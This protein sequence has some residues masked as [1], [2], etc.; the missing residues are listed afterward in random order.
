MRHRLLGNFIGILLGIALNSALCST[1]FAQKNDTL[2]WDL[3]KTK[4]QTLT[5]R[6]IDSPRIHIISFHP[7]GNQMCHALVLLQRGEYLP[8][9]DI[10]INDSLGRPVQR[11]DYAQGV[12][13]NYFA[14]GKINNVLTAPRGKTEQRYLEYYSNG[15]IKT[16]EVA[17]KDT[18][19]NGIKFFPPHL[20]SGNRL[21]PY[22]Y[23]NEKYGYYHRYEYRPNG[24]RYKTVSIQKNGTYV[25]KL[26]NNK[27]AETVLEGDHQ[28][29]IKQ[30]WYENGNMRSEE[31]FLNGIAHGPYRRWYEDGTPEL[32]QFKKQNQN[33]SIMRMWYPDGSLKHFADYRH[34]S[35]SDGPQMRFFPNGRLEHI[36]AGSLTCRYDSLGNI[37]VEYVSGAGAFNISNESDRARFLHQGEMNPTRQGLWKIYSVDGVLR[38]Q[39]TYV[40]G[41]IEGEE[42]TYY[43]NGTLAQ[44]INY[45]Q[46]WKNGWSIAYATNGTDTMYCG[47][48]LNNRRT[49]IW[50][51]YHTN[52]RI[53]E[54]TQY[55]P[56][57]MGALQLLKADENGKVQVKA[58]YNKEK[59]QME[60]SYYYEDGT[61]GNLYVLKDGY[62][63]DD[64]YEYYKSGKLK[65]TREYDKD[66]IVHEAKMY[67]ESGALRMRSTLKDNK[68]DGKS[69]EWYE[70][71]N[72]KSEGIWVNGLRDDYW[73]FWN[74]DG[75]PDRRVK[76][77]KGVEMP[78]ESET[79][80]NKL[81]CDCFEIPEPPPASSF[82]NPIGVLI[83]RDSINSRLDRFFIDADF[84]KLY[85]KN[86]MNTTREIIVLQNFKM[87]ISN[88]SMY[89][90]LTPCRKG[91]NRTLITLRGY[92]EDMNRFNYYVKS[93]GKNPSL[94]QKFTMLYTYLEQR[95]SFRLDSAM[96]QYT[97][98][99]SV[100]FYKL[101]SRN[102]GTALP[103]QIDVDAYYNTLDEAEEHYE[104]L[105]PDTEVTFEES[106]AEKMINWIYLYEDIKSSD[107]EL[108]Q[109]F[110]QTSVDDNSLQLLL[111]MLRGYYTATLSNGSLRLFTG[112]EKLQVC[113]EKGFVQMGTDKKPMQPG[114]LMS[115]KEL[116]Y[117]GKQGDLIS[118][119]ESDITS[120]CAP[121]F[122]IANSGLVIKTD[123]FIPDLCS[124]DVQGSMPY[125]MKYYS[126]Y[127]YPFHIND[128][129]ISPAADNI[130]HTYNT[131]AFLKKF[132]GLI[133]QS[134]TIFL[135][136]QQRTLVFENI[137]LNDE[138]LCGK[139]VLPDDISMEQLQT[140]LKQ[141]GF[142]IYVSREDMKEWKPA[143]QR[144]YVRYRLK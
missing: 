54:I 98:N 103:Q 27:D 72:K 1:V 74:E 61:L 120:S 47:N 33:D 86:N 112:N 134:G 81:Q 14:N 70:S 7:N 60:R 137:L 25:T 82:Y 136:K 44:I 5:L 114:F 105:N 20:N 142:E 23:Q 118:F 39:A 117:D 90:D 69:T 49:G 41:I 13:T 53:Y 115:Y 71:G 12:L 45:H 141:Q 88:S 37:V 24:A 9:A 58:V 42:R 144:C 124:N 126:E 104:E 85:L 55:T 63:H 99:D 130:K 57:G 109:R 83:S 64:S 6:D 143:E 121:V 8:Q 89:M 43:A 95:G 73:M 18:N 46:G 4:I 96:M 111:P 28:L 123:R 128:F 3:R 139:V 76:F 30:E 129:R 132:M 107:N 48:H 56:D 21:L 31:Y 2:Y 113:N 38:Y 51:S 108:L 94:V 101:M 17:R 78:D 10:Q 15:S 35:G 75:S 91:V 52:G 102:Y 19:K 97:P 26:Y 116:H 84:G 93:Y 79:P 135:T 87:R 36:T 22:M 110:F 32:E 133:L 16:E 62:K 138:E 34:S 119:R 59:K 40:N 29:N 100:A 80:D 122:T 67:Y 131:D 50:R 68:M 125:D 66:G 65:L 106:L 77:V 92:Y 11:F 140:M 127:D